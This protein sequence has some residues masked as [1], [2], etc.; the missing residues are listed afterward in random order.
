MIAS[1]LSAP[2]FLFTLSGAPRG[3]GAQ[4]S[5]G[6]RGSHGKLWEEA[7]PV[8]EEAKS[9]LLPRTVDGKSR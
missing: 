2:P 6:G 8:Q 9:E 1:A 7:L 4:G 3:D 5:A